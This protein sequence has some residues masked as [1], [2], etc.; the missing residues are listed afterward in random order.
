MFNNGKPDFDTLAVGLSVV[1]EMNIGKMRI[2]QIS[3]Q[4]SRR[5]EKGGNINL[6]STP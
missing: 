2:M 5:N 1:S 3:C 4:I 6:S